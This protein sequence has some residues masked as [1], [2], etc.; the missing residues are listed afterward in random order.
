MFLVGLSFLLHTSAA[1]L[2]LA[3][4]GVVSSSE[5]GSVF[6]RGSIICMQGEA[7]LLKCSLNGKGNLHL[8]DK[9]KGMGLDCTH[10][11]HFQLV[12]SCTPQKCVFSFYGVQ[13]MAVKCAYCAF[14]QLQE[15]LS[16]G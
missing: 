5:G 3:D 1:P 8:P 7:S 6:R 16:S 10:S 12:F 2:A 14:C 11:F 13:G 9:G 4:L 15:W